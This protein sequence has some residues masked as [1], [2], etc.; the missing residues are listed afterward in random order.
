L[1]SF[2]GTPLMRPKSSKCSRTVSRSSRASCC[3]Q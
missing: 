1:R 3:G 2:S